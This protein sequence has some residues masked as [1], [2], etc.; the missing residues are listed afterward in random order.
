MTATLELRGVSRAHGSG[1][2]RVDALLEANPLVEPGKM[3]AVMG[4]QWVGE[5]NAALTCR[6]SR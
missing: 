5:D 3:V 2:V 6:R 4:P 1:H